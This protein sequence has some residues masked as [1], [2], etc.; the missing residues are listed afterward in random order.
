MGL[1]IRD[2]IISTEGK[3]IK[4]VL[5]DVAISSG[6]DVITFLLCLAAVQTGIFRPLR[7]TS[8]IHVIDSVCGGICVII[9][10]STS[11]LPLTCDQA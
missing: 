7:M 10:G 4:E 8:N 3:S 6:L 5:S 11:S 2:R 9:S 1:K